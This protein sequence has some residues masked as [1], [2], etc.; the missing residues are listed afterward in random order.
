MSNKVGMNVFLHSLLIIKEMDDFTVTE[1]RDALLN[2]H[3]EFINKTETRKFIYR[4]LCRN[5]E[6][7]LI[8]RTE[9]FK[10]GSKQIVYSKT[11]KLLESTVTPI[12][13]RFKSKKQPILKERI[14]IKEKNYKVELE[15][16]LIA[17]EIDLNTTLEEAQE[18]KRLYSRFPALKDELQRHQ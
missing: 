4:Q 17:Y 16:D 10:D 2:G 18:Y 5:I 8:K 7:G 14:G 11:K 3:N 13:R 6:K 1:A 9:Q 12:K 15:K